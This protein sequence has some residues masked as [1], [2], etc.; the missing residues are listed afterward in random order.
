M[1]TAKR[2]TYLSY[3]V[4]R[5]FV[6]NIRDLYL[7]EAMLLCSIFI[8]QKHLRTHPRNLSRVLMEPPGY[9]LLTPTNNQTC[10]IHAIT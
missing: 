8:L 6:L 5:M 9:L 7:S 10:N 3:N 2:A 4:K 1:Y